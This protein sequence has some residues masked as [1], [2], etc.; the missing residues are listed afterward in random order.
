MTQ[1]ANLSLQALKG[2]FRKGEFEQARDGLQAYLSARPDDASALALQRHLDNLEALKGIRRAILKQ[3]W[4]QIVDQVE[5]ALEMGLTWDIELSPLTMLLE[6][7][8]QRRTKVADEEALS[9]LKQA[10]DAEEKQALTPARQIYAR[11][12]ALPHLTPALRTKLQRRL[13]AL[14]PGRSA[15]LSTVTV[16][17]RPDALTEQLVDAILKKAPRQ[18]AEGIRLGA[19]P[20]FFDLELLSALREGDDGLDEKVLNR[21]DRL[22][23]VH[24]DDRDL[25]FLEQDVRAYLLNGWRDDPQGFVEANRRAQAYFLEQLRATFPDGDALLALTQAGQVAQ[26]RPL[27]GASPEVGELVQNYLYHTLA[28]D[29]NVGLALL[30]RLFRAAAEAHRPALAERYVNIANEQRVWLKPDQRAY[31][32]YMRGLL[33]QLQEKWDASRDLFERMLKR[34]GL[35][36]TLQARVRRALGN[37]LIEQE[38]WVEAIA[39]FKAAL[40]AF[41]AAGD[42]LESALTMV[43]RGRA[44]L[45]LALNTWGGGITFGLSRTWSGRIRD[46]LMFVRRLPLILYLMGRLGVRALFPI[47]LHVGRG[48]DWPIAR[49]F[50]IAAA[51]FGRAETI[52]RRLGDEDGL[53]QVEESLARLY[54]SLGQFGQAE[55]IYRRLLTPG[56]ISLSDYRAA[57][58]RLRLAQALMHQGDLSQARELC[59]QLLP[60]FVAHHHTERIAQTHT[61][62]AQTFALSGRSTRAIAH[63]QQAVQHYYQLGDEANTT[64]I[65]EQMQLLHDQPQTNAAARQSIETTASQI[66]RRRYLTSF[67]LPALNMFR[68]VSQAGLAGVLFFSLLTLVRVESGVGLKVSEASLSSKTTASL[69]EPAITFELTPQLKSSFKV[70]SSAYLIVIAITV[71]LVIY[72]LYGLWITIRTPLR[73]L[74]EGQRLDIVIDSD[75]VGRGDEGVP[76]S[77]KLRWEQVTALLSSDRGMFRRPISFFSRLVLIGEDPVLIGEDPVLIGEDPVLVGE[78]NVVVIDGRTRR[79][80]AA[81]DFVQ[82]QLSQSAHATD[83]PAQGA[84]QPTIIYEFGF[85]VLRSHSG[86]L[87]VGTLAA[88]LVFIVIAWVSPERLTT[89]LGALPY[90]LASLYTISYLGLLIPGVWWLAFQPLR[91]RLLL[92]PYTRHVWLVGLAGLLL[93]ALTFIDLYWL[94]F[95]VRL[96]NVMPGLGLVGACLVGL[97]AWYVGRTRRWERMPFRRGEHV[98][99]LPLRLALGA[100]A[101]AIIVLTLGLVGRELGVYH[102]V[103]QANLHWKQATDASEDGYSA[104]A[105]ERYK[106]ALFHYDQALDWGDKEASTYHSRAAILVQLKRYGEAVASLNKAISRDPQAAYYNSR[107]IAYEKWATSQDDCDEK[108]A[109][110]CYELACNDF[111]TALDKMSEEDDGRV[112]TYLSRA[113][114]YLQMGEYYYRNETGGDQ[115]L[116]QMNYQKARDDYA[117]VIEMEDDNVAAA[118]NGR[119]WMRYR[120]A[121]FEKDLK[122]LE[123]QGLLDQRREDLGQALG[124]LAQAD[125]IDR[126]QLTTLIGIG[127][128]HFAIG[129]TFTWWDE[130]L[131]DYRSAC[132]DDER[133]LNPRSLDE[134]KSYEDENRQAIKIFTRAAELAD[135]A[136]LFSISG[137]IYE[138]L[139][140]C[141]G[142]DSDKIRSAAIESFSEALKLKPDNAEWLLK[143]ATHYYSLDWDDYY[144]QYTD[145]YE[146]YVT[147]EPRTGVYRLLGSIYLGHEEWDKAFQSFARAIELNPTNADWRRELGDIYREQGDLDKAIQSYTKATELNP[148][149][150]DWHG[151][152]GEFYGEQGDLEKAVQAYADAV[153]LEPDN[154][155]WQGN[156]GWYA[157]ANGDYQRS[158][159][160][161]QAAVSLNHDEPTLFFNWGLA[162]VAMG[163]AEEAWRVYA[164]GVEATNALIDTDALDRYG[165]ALGDLGDVHQDP[166]G[167]AD[168]LR[169]HLTF[170]KALIYLRAGSNEVWST[171][172]EGIDIAATL[173]EDTRRTLYDEAL[174]DLRA[175]DPAS[176]LIIRLVRRLEEARGE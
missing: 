15:A 4:D 164:D 103:A 58:A 171:Y 161:S 112:I 152:L 67:N 34:E 160:A 43:N 14:Q 138:H 49:L 79:Y 65:V 120:L 83:K 90:S 109:L 135:D 174:D 26:L 148:T 42:D 53:G 124:D 159:E 30:R 170:K 64:E 167:I 47:P 54:L 55:A 10:E 166:S 126:E 121:T 140:D 158:V 129:E 132:Y 151:K 91:E 2:L 57:K 59:Q 168:A 165:G 9:L 139:L 115:D 22:S 106:E 35:P 73:T 100:A 45:E 136:V 29:A 76:G 144:Q 87:F 117:S 102:Y 52:L 128:A 60:I 40:R 119:G 116:A 143:R 78:E 149:N 110:H 118:L 61:T 70:D 173:N 122:G 77:S 5:A 123:E 131:G 130:G 66:T 169:T 17:M 96:P 137:I 12:A 33:D 39:L 85:D 104:L 75:G 157:Y 27:I 48:M 108:G 89:N 150:D 63:Y 38:Q 41:Q 31:V 146:R 21:M 163:E 32:D 114:I 92:N 111:G 44:H 162:L 37:T 3:D 51:W 25:F 23:F 93:I 127:F 142:V 36:P 105:Q 125:S 74:Q 13:G 8:E 7:A 6:S 84:K 88:I 69:F 68:L 154:Y 18:V 145:D 28:A 107:A 94:R 82:R 50:A 98:Y 155:T 46:L 97:A 113:G 62:L 11:A 147:L 141:P 24:E 156:L 56:G 80:L 16:M 133:K 175:I 72:T 176:N 99:A 1:N 172:R 153:E 95:Y 71:Y 134:K 19:I 101:L 81:R 86:R 20:F